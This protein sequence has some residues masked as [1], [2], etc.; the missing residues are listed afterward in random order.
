MIAKLVA[1]CLTAVLTVPLLSLPGLLRYDFVPEASR[2]LPGR[3]QETKFSG[4][5][6]EADRIG[7]LGLVSGKYHNNSWIDGRYNHNDF[8]VE[9]GRVTAAGTDQMFD[10]YRI[11]PPLHRATKFLGSQ[12]RIYYRFPFKADWRVY[13]LAGD[14]IRQVAAVAAEQ[15]N[16]E[17]FTSIEGVS[18][19]KLT[20]PTIYFF[21]PAAIRVSVYPLLSGTVEGA[22]L[23]ATPQAEVLLYRHPF[24]A[25]PPDAHRPPSGVSRQFFMI[26]GSAGVGVL[27]QDQQ[28]QA[29]R[30]TRFSSDLR[31]SDSITLPAGRPGRLLAACADPEGNLYYL[32]ARGKDD[33]E[34]LEL[35]KAD[36]TGALLVR[37][38]PDTSQTALNIFSM[39][40]EA[41][42][43]A[44]SNGKLC[45]MLMHTKHKSADGVN[46]QGGLA[47]I[48]SAADLKL[49][50]NL[51]QTSGH[52]FDNVL[53]VNG[54]GEFIGMDL[55]DNF[56]RGIHL[57]RLSEQRK[58]SRV[59]Y[60]FKTEHGTTPASRS[61][62]TYPEYPEISTAG[63]MYYK[64]SNDNRTY[65]ELGGVL[66]TPQ[67]YAVIF[68]GEPSP[69]GRVLDNSRSGAKSPD[70]RNIG[71]LHVVKQFD[72]V[73]VKGRNM[74][75]DELLLSKGTPE[76]GG[77]YS[78]QGGWTEQRS[79]GV[80]WLT[81][82]TADEGISARHIKTAPLSDGTILILWETVRQ[83][84]HHA[85]WAMT[86]TGE[87]IPVR[88]PFR[89]P[90]QIGLNRRDAVMA[91]GTRVYIA[92]G[93]AG[94]KR[95]ELFVLQVN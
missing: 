8:P 4:D 56:P 84:K 32:L 54:A 18:V 89:L 81:R 48:F 44:W 35:I 67:G 45:M 74:V 58:N 3:T 75:P 29:I 91:D 6:V 1:V 62:A 73:P 59:I 36:R 60:T 25:S 87:G 77:F 46:H 7:R 2:T 47:V 63:R 94:D 53:L 19:S 72:R 92:S 71:F 88:A 42:E 61:G 49:L 21:A 26:R 68:A 57:H 9:Q 79:T 80:V 82:Y 39:G 27:W 20:E 24:E 86:V 10:A 52:S 51:G 55:G 90:D 78:Y 15:V 12:H 22:R 31:S 5:V 23:V 37:S 13:Q 65:T 40:A 93:D 14:A 11:S 28:T 17:Q 83:G 69:D 33:P 43:L 64:W 66:E 85:N 95:L 76:T 16:P 41:A 50:K 38:A 34:K 30:L 70:M